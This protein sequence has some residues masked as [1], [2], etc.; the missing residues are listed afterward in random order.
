V[1]SPTTGDDVFVVVSLMQSGDVEV[2]LLRG[3]PKLPEDG[4]TAP[5]DPA[6]IFAVFDLSRK[7]GPCAY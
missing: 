1:A 4:G 7:T 3:A 2:R 6:N 5:A